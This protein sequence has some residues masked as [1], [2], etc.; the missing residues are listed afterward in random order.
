MKKIML[1]SRTGCGKTAL[2]QALKGKL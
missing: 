2:I 1:V